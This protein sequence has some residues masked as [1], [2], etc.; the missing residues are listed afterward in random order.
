MGAMLNCSSSSVIKRIQQREGQ[1]RHERLQARAQL[2]S[3][4][5]LKKI[6]FIL[7]NLS[8]RIVYIMTPASAVEAA[9]SLVACQEE[10]IT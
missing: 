4:E 6:V 9:C 2:S 1:R 5:A 7:Y 3:R 10:H 8:C